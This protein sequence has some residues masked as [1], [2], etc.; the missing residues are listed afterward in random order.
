MHGSSRVFN[1]IKKIAEFTHN[2]EKKSEIFPICCFAPKRD[3]ICGVLFN[4]CC[5]VCGV[6]WRA[7]VTTEQ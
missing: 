6:H 1:E 4:H 5:A 3:Q 2:T 7:P